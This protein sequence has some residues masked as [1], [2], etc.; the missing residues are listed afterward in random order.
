MYGEIYIMGGVVVNFVGSD[1]CSLMRD[2][3][4]V[5]YLWMFMGN[6]CTRSINC[7]YV[8]TL[9]SQWILN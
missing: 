2:I 6:V 1:Y 4:N 5:T 7:G 9:T 8:V 3:T